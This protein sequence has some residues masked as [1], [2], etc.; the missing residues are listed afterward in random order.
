M[1]PLCCPWVQ[2][3]CSNPSLSRGGCYQ[4]YKVSSLLVWSKAL[5]PSSPPFFFYELIWLPL[6]SLPLPLG[7]VLPD[8]IISLQGCYLRSPKT[9]S[10]VHCYSSSLAPSTH[11]LGSCPLTPVQQKAKTW[12][13]SAKNTKCKVP[14]PR[15]QGLVPVDTM[16]ASRRISCKNAAPWYSP[17]MAFS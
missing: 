2:Q 1:L 15:K 14:E 5:Q 17:I 6:S 16:V 13:R 3:P 9:A 12:K 8:I 7:C 11:P 10:K 4:P